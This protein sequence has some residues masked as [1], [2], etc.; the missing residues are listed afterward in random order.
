LS[1]LV[2]RER[3]GTIMR[4]AALRQELRLC[5][6]GRKKLGLQRCQDLSVDW[7]ASATQQGAV[8]CILD[9]RVLERVFGIGRCSPPED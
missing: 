6:D 2:R 3:G 7:L 4:S 1:A 9:Q 8:S 5:C